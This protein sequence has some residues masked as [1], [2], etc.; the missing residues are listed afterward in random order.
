MKLKTVKIITYLLL[1]VAVLLI[2]AVLATKQR[3]YGIAATVVCIGA[4]VFEST[5]YKCPECGKFLGSFSNICCPS[6]GCKVREDRKNK[7]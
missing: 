7:K 6:C 4:G 3:P 5:F 2:L 1:A